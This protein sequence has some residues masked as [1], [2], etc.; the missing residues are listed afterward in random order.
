M[1]RKRT[2]EDDKVIK[3]LV[4]QELLPL[5]RQTFP[6]LKITMKELR[7]RM[8]RGT[9]YVVEQDAKGKHRIDGFVIA[10][11]NP[12]DVW[13]DMLAVGR[14][15]QGKGLGSALLDKAEEEGRRKG[16]VNAQLFVDGVNSKAQMFYARKGYMITGYVQE[17]KCYQMT[18]A[19]TAS[20]ATSG[21]GIRLPAPAW[22]GG[23]ALPWK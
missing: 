1:I 2:A 6:G 21:F 5:A 18:K 9:A 23:P 15:H 8:K 20:K 13:I 4:E 14:E 17:V 12:Q 11:T 10:V 19:L 7:E 22:D 16:C 3:W